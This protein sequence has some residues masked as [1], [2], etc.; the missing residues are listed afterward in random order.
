MG[1][2]KQLVKEE[3]P[4]ASSTYGASATRE[5][6][7]TKGKEDWEGREVIIIHDD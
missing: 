6:K 4:N 1:V 7:R 5:T 3:T 2:E